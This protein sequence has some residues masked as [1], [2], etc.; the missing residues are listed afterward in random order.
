[1][2]LKT[3]RDYLISDNFEEH[4]EGSCSR[5]RLCDSCQPN[6]DNRPVD[7]ATIDAIP[8]IK[9]ELNELSIQFKSTCLVYSQYNLVIAHLATSGQEMLGL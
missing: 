7:Q 3:R 5:K 8:V 6:M 4:V 2:I 9:N 1:M